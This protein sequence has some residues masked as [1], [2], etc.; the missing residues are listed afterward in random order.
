MHVE[1]F[2]AVS[3]TVGIG[4]AASRA[5]NWIRIRRRAEQAP[6]DIV[7]AA[8]ELVEARR[9][10]VSFSSKFQAVDNKFDELEKVV[11][12]YLDGMCTDEVETVDSEV[13]KLSDYV[14]RKAS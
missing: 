4:F 1:I 13:V 6:A 7:A 14:K 12:N 11:V 3:L 9:S 5:V 10:K 8:I 2:I